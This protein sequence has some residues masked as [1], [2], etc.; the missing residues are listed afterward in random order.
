MDV[1]VKDHHEGSALMISDRPRI[2]RWVAVARDRGR[3]L[4]HEG[5][6]AGHR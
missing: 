2:A 3:I 1:A 5:P 4:A 6:S